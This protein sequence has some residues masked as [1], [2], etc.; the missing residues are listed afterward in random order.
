MSVIMR[1]KWLS[2]ARDIGVSRAACQAAKVESGKGTP[3]CITTAPGH[4]RTLTI[5]DKQNA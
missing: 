3:T 2:A 5:G 4:A 1:N